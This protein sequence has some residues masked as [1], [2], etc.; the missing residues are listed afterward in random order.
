MNR[1][2]TIYAS[3][4]TG[5]WAVF[6]QQY[7]LGILGLVY[8]QDIPASTWIFRHNL[9][10]LPFLIEFFRF[11]D[12]GTRVDYKPADVQIDANIITVQ[13]GSNENI[14]GAIVVLFTNPAEFQLPTPTPSSTITPT[15][16]PT[17][18]ITL[19]PT[20]TIT[21]TITATVTPTPTV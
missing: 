4:E 8:I 14:T 10:K 21:P 19:M 13:N 6:D 3:K 7:D 17:P 9:N 1:Y 2:Q 15:P 16:T 18:T 11:E 5:R 20:N 12:D